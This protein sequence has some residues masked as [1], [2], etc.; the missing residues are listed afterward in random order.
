MSIEENLLEQHNFSDYRNFHFSDL[1]KEYRYLQK[2]D[3]SLDAKDSILSNS[4]ETAYSQ[5]K[6]QQSSFD[7][8]GYKII[9]SSIYNPSFSFEGDNIGSEKLEQKIDNY[10]INNFTS[11][12]NYSELRQ[13]GEPNDTFATAVDTNLSANN[14][15]YQARGTIGNNGGASAS[16][17][18]DY[19]LVELNAGDRIKVDVDT[20]G[21]SNL[22]SA[23]RIFSENGRRVA[24]NDN[25]AA[26]GESNTT[27]S[28]I[29]FTASRSGTYY[30]RVNSKSRR[31]SGEYSLNIDL[32]TDNTPPDPNPDPNPN[33]DSGFDIKINFTD[34]SL[35]AS[36]RAVF[37]QAAAKWSRVIT[38]DLPDVNV[39]GFGF[40]DDLVI[41]ASAPFIDGNGSILGQAGPTSFRSGSGLPS[42]GE[43]EFDSADVAQLERNGGLE[44]VIVHEM[45]HVLGIGTIWSRKGLLTGAGTSDPRFTGR[46]ATAEYNRIFG[47]NESS[48]PVANTGGRGTR[49][50]HWRESILGNELMTGFLNNGVSNPLSS[51]TVASLGDLGYEVDLSAADPYSTPRSF[52]TDTSS[53]SIV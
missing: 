51:I 40:V 9:T 37:T 46:G 13:G 12:S 21:S 52:V 33:P 14:T 27:D 24:N 11:S 18:V 16:S 44:A 10:S 31:S 8:G 26:P 41:D 49:D 53:N 34:N 43:M 2:L 3:I 35:T 17:D 50:G 22:D 6:V 47:R 5:T 19:F 32:Q 30:I 45:G 4:K 20:P 48:V 25:G 36:Q 42:R 29:D 23:L 7:F 1:D 39:R 38:G 28:Y 15:S